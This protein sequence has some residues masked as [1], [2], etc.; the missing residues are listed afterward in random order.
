MEGSLCKKTL[1]L[2][3]GN[4][5]RSLRNGFRCCGI[6]L[7]S[8]PHTLLFP[9]SSSSNSSRKEGSSDSNPISDCIHLKP[10]FFFNP[11]VQELGRGRGGGPVLRVKRDHRRRPTACPRAKVSSVGDDLIHRESDQKNTYHHRGWLMVPIRL[12]ILFSSPGS[13][14]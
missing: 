11:S 1:L 2:W 9:F 6:F 8:H 12:F 10:I 13:V 3:G 4:E 7:C 5:Q 14:S